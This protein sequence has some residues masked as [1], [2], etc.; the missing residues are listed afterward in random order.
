MLKTTNINSLD[1]K[2]NLTKCN[3]DLDEMTI[4][5]NKTKHVYDLLNASL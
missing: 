1:V 2:A 4:L 5:Q 3:E